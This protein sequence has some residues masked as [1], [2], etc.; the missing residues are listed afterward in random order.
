MSKYSE[1]YNLRLNRFGTDHTSR[2]QGARERNFEVF[3]EK[4]PSRVEFLFEE[5]RQSAVLERY[6]QDETET[7]QYLLT[8]RSL[9]LPHGAILD[10]Q[11]PQWDKPWM[12]LYKENITARGYNKYV[13]LKMTHY[14]TWKTEGG[15]VHQSWSYLSG[16]GSSAIKNAIMNKSNS[17]YTENNNLYKIVMPYT[18][19][20][21]RNVYFELDGDAFVVTGVDKYST[22]GITYVSIDPV[23]IRNTAAAPSKQEGD[24]DEDFF[25]LQGGNN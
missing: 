5:E 12:I 21:Q 14:L 22:E 10:I 6:K 16:P 7:L 1:I 20:L 9:E 17:V 19:A 3:L 4:S 24:N 25:W 13:I 2:V 18:A 8:K 11:S 15:Q 23:A